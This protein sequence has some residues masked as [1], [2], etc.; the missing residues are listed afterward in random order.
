MGRRFREPAFE[1]CVINSFMRS[2]QTLYAALA[3]LALTI[4]VTYPLIGQ[5]STHI[6]GLP[7]NDSL[8]F[9]W[10]VWWFKHSLLD[11][12]NNPLNIL[13]LNYPEGL[14]FPLLPAMSQSFLLALPIAA[15]ISPVV[16]FN[17]IFLLSFPLCALAG[18]WLCYDL[19]QDRRAAFLGGLIW[20]FF[21]NKS[22]HAMAGHLFQLVVFTLPIAALFLLRTLR[23][24]SRR[25]SILAGIALALAATIHPVNVAY[26]L[27]PLLIVIVGF[28][29]WDS[30]RSQK[31]TSQSD[32]PT[33][34]PSLSTLFKA[35]SIIAITGGLLSLP[36][37]LP[38]LLSRDQLGFLVE[39]GVVGFSLDLLHLVINRR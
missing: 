19:T 28:A 36:L 34:H 16:A 38:T 22:A 10:S 17:I 11:L 7:G 3:Y 9:V 23:S 21:P 13:V 29:L 15:L 18:Y 2:R 37:F 26:F 20:G 35:L 5:L 6:A 8:E 31:S 30:Y 32:P 1:G 39:R 33:P 4:A 24:P 12:H 27:L 14:Y 25:N